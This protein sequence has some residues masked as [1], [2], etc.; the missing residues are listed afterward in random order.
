MS[1]SPLPPPDPIVPHLGPPGIP[2]AVHAALWSTQVLAGR[3]DSA[4]LPD[5]AASAV[6][7]VTPGAVSLLSETMTAWR[8][9]GEQVVL[10]VHPRPGR[11]GTFPVGVQALGASMAPDA[12]GV[13]LAPSLGDAFVL[14][15]TPFGHALD[16]G[17]LLDAE[18]LPSNPVPHHR[19]EAVDLRTAQRSFATALRGGLEVLEARGGSPVWAGQRT[20]GPEVSTAGDLPAGLDGE[21]LDLLERAAAVAALTTDGL[22]THTTHAALTETRH[23][24]MSHL[25]HAALDALEAGALA[26]ARGLRQPGRSGRA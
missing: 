14:H 3:L 2:V 26:A 10:P 8:D 16:G 21:V 22:S 7:A 11:P 19:I 23:R 25:H 12:V 17:W 5:R 15:L 13:L 20:G 1:E 24:A 4:E 9:V 18:R 6:E